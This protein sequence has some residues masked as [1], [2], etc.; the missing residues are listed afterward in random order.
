MQSDINYRFTSPPDFSSFG[1][2]P[3]CSSIGFS[4]QGVAGSI[5]ASR[6]FNMYFKIIHI[7]C[8]NMIF[9]INSYQ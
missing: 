7:K 8:C 6:K 5:P 2:A 1:R 4:N 9:C 3:D